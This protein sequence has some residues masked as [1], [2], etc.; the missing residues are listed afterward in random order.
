MDFNREEFKG[1]LDVAKLAI[2]QRD[3]IPILSHFC[4]TGRDLIAYNDL[5]GVRVP[6]KSNF[7]CALQATTLLRLVNSTQA[8]EI[9]IGFT[10]DTA[11]LKTGKAGKGMR[12]RL[13]YIGE[14]GFFF[15]WPSVK[16]ME[17]YKLTEGQAKS[18][19]RGLR[20]CL[21][22]VGEQNITQMGVVINGTPTKT[23]LNSTNNKAISRYSMKLKLP[24]FKNAIL[25]ESF[26]K[27]VIKAGDTYGLEGV[28]VRYA[29]EFAIIEFGDA[30]SVYTKMLP[31]K[32]PLDFQKVIRA[33]LPSDYKA[34]VRKFDKELEESFHRALII[35]SNELTKTV[36]VHV[37]A[38]VVTVGA[39]SSLGKLKSSAVFS[40]GL[41][42][43]SFRVDAEFAMQA[44]ENTDHV[45]FSEKA[46]I[47]FKGG[48][49][50]ML[51]TQAVE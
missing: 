2:D 27:A 33:H 42:K 20:L 38:N 3:F 17:S 34:R 39:R 24:C 14:E 35:L 1:M 49:M 23:L 36:D 7:I 5:I 50:H 48:Y 9:S 10:G 43:F 21:T 11:Y 12:A 30:C 32:D 51:A 37:D 25:P 13:P 15:K 8:A 18:F 31:N 47:F 26:C 44:I 40:H 4:F 41:G 6:C 22:S 46:I 19:I 45:F 16:K 28:T 29:K